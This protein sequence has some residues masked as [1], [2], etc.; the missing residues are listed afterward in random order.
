MNKPQGVL[1]ILVGTARFTLCHMEV[2]IGLRS[3]TEKLG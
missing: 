2:V 3:V 1:H